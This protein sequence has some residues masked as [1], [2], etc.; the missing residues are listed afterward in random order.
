MKLD[1]VIEL[2]A[3]ESAVSEEIHIIGSGSGGVAMGVES[4]RVC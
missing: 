1:L 2:H 4:L 3:W